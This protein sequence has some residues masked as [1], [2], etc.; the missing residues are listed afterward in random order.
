MNP[1]NATTCLTG[2]KDGISFELSVKIEGTP[3]KVYKEEEMGGGG[4]QAWIVSEEGK[5]SLRYLLA[6]FARLI[7]LGCPVSRVV[8]DL[9][10]VSPFIL[11]SR[12]QR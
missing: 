6:S 4:S 9:D 3:A 12:T 5:V 7:A 8:G 10:S 11:K 1:V 2:K